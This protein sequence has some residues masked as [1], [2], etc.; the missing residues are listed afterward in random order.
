M[1]PSQGQG[2]FLEKGSERED[3]LNVQEIY[4]TKHELGIWSM[5]LGMTRDITFPTNHNTTDFTRVDVIFL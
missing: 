5:R 2:N 4:A 1:H 3:Q